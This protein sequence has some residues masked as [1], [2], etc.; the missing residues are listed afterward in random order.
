MKNWNIFKQKDMILNEKD[1]LEY[2]DSIN[3]CVNISKITISSKKKK[4]IT[5]QNRE[6]SGFSQ[7]HGK[8]TIYIVHMTHIQRTPNLSVHIAGNDVLPR[9]EN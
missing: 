1:S 2:F 3:M 9:T 4:I 8:S 5:D 6:I 7:R